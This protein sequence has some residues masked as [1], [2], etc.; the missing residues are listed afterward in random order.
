MYGVRV[1]RG[2]RDFLE[3]QTGLEKRQAFDVTDSA[4]NLVRRP[5]CLRTTDTIASLSRGTI[6][7]GI[8]PAASIV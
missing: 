7:A 5:R 2:Q 3:V 6:S 4:A 1:D 8:P